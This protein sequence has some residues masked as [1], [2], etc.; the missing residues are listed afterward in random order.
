MPSGA[1]AAGVAFTTTTSYSDYCHAA[2]TT[3]SAPATTTGAVFAP[4]TVAMLLVSCYLLLFLHLQ[5]IS[6]MILSI[7]SPNFSA[8]DPRPQ[9]SHGSTMAVALGIAQG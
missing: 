1:A 2:A 3:I 8:V 9:R 6:P 4:K 7:S 5:S